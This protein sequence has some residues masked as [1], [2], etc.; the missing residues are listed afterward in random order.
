MN[1]RGPVPRL[2]FRKFFNHTEVV[3]FLQSLGKARPD[4]CR[5]G[6]LG[7]SREGRELAIAT[8]T[9]HTSGRADD[10]PGYLIHGNIH[11]GEVAGTHAALH[12][13]RQLLVD[14]PKSS[15]L[16]KI[17]FYIVPRLNPDGAEH[18]VTTSGRIRSR[19]EWEEAPNTLV[20]ED[21]DGDGRILS[22][23]QVQP[24]GAWA[25]DPED[26]R[27]LVKRKAD[28]KEAFL[29]NASGGSDPRMG[30]E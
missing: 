6:S 27:L 15:I 12:T 20:Q 11:A 17:T 10:K 22:M 13:A 4:L 28:S 23:R 9:D 8:I 18:V 16:K 26:P 24:D 1:A 19:T 29:Q 7:R 3:R 21:L 2:P 5:I 25:K 30:R 14:H